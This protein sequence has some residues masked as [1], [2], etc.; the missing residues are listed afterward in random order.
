MK[1]VKRI[2]TIV[3]R[4]LWGDEDKRRFHLVKW[5]DV[6]KPIDQGGLGIKFIVEMNVAFQIK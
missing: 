5:E 1:V 4:F 3:Y 6:K 2:E